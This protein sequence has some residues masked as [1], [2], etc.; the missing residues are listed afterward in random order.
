VC[1]VCSV[2]K[3][4]LDLAFLLVLFFGEAQKMYESNGLP[5]QLDITFIE[6]WQ[7]Q[8]AITRSSTMNF[9]ECLTTTCAINK[10]SPLL[11]VSVGNG[12]G[13]HQQAHTSLNIW[14]CFLFVSSQ[15]D[16]SSER[17]RSLFHCYMS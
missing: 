7:I 6:A 2:L 12:G 15:S 14:Y 8:N 11:C 13:G 17:S 9:Y 4:L 10:I 16:A 5:L 1:S 3:N